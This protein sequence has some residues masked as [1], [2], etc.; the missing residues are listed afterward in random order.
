[1]NIKSDEL[2]R[3]DDNTSY[4]NGYRVVY[5]DDN[6]YYLGAYCKSIEG[7]MIG[8]ADSDPILSEDDI[9]KFVSIDDLLSRFLNSMNDINKV[10]IYNV[11]G[12]CVEA[13][14][15]NE[16]EKKI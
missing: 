13:K 11:D 12:T 7:F 5:F 4:D 16:I 1:M 9:P 15:K 8:F 3:I 14:E 6:N 10:A 2:K